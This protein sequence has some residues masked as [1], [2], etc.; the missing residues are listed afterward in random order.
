VMESIHAQYYG[1]DRYRPVA[2]ARNRMVAGLLGRKTHQGF[3]TYENGVQQ[4]PAMP[5][6]AP[7]L[8]TTCWWPQSGPN[9]LSPELADLLSTGTRV[10]DNRFADIVWVAPL[11]ADLSSTVVQ[12]GLDPARVVAIDPV[13][14]SRNGVTLMV[15]PATESAT[16]EHAQGLLASQGIPSFVIA[17][18]PG[19]V[20]P[21]VIAC[22]INL[23]C[24]MAQQGVAKPTDIDA[25]VRLGLGYPAGPFEWGDRLGASR[26]LEI[27]C[28]LH[29][30]F[31]DQRYRASPWLVRR[32]RLGLSLCAPDRR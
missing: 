8:Q 15:S 31:G 10:A 6:V 4:Q 3:Y 2:L 16:I 27:L 29:T 17:D 9:A 12:L 23:A 14:S 26:I 24:E 25:A 21:R 13:F 7:I 19:Y 30:T 5:A 28:G 20:A 18:S 11:G 32:A 1:D 22:I